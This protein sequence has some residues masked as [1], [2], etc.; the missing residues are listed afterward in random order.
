M[1][2][3]SP[4]LTLAFASLLLY[5]LLSCPR[6]RTPTVQYSPFL[7]PASTTFTLSSILPTRLARPSYTLDTPSLSAFYTNPYLSPAVAPH[8][9]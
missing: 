4:A 2:L 9:W 1:I 8:L 6:L 5:S 3:L 7:D